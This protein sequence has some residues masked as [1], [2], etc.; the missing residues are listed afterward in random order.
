MT[1]VG[2][3]KRRLWE[4]GIERGGGKGGGGGGGGGLGGGGGG[5]EGEGE[6]SLVSPPSRTGAVKNPTTRQNFFF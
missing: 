6:K 3:K 1:V 4:K 2:E 5:G